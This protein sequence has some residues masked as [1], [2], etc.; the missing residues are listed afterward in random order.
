MTLPAVW[1]FSGGIAIVLTG[2]LNLL[3]RSYGATAWGLRWFCVVSTA[4]MT[5]FSL[6]AGWV[7]R[8]GVAELIIIGGWMGVTTVLSLMRST[9][10]IRR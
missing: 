9:L 2:G 3:S 4:G 1:F 6:I 10:V 5:V 7:G 8:A